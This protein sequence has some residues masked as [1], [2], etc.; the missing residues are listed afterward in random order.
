MK[1]LHPLESSKVQFS[2]RIFTDAEKVPDGVKG[3]PLSP[4][5]K[6]APPLENSI[7]PPN[8]CGYRVSVSSPSTL[9]PVSAS[10]SQAPE[11]TVGQPMA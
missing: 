10:P 7:L 9:R 3:C 5:Y 2:P 1:P 6:A 11:S 8:V 4:P